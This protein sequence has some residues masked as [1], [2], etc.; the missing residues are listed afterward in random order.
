MVEFDKNN[1]IVKNIKKNIKIDEVKEKIK[2]MYNVFHEITNEDNECTFSVHRLKGNDYP[3]FSMVTIRVVDT[4]IYIEF[5]TNFSLKD[6]VYDGFFE[7][8]LSFN[9]EKNIVFGS[10][11][12]DTDTLSIRSRMYCN[13]LEDISTFIERSTYFSSDYIEN[14]GFIDSIKNEEV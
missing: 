9:Y 8:L 10:I 11:D 14:I 12:K 7:K 1:N 4:I 6:F 2:L 5:S 13:D 3:Y